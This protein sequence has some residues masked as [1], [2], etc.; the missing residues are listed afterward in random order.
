MNFLKGIRDRLSG[1]QLRAKV[2]LGIIVPLV[3]VLGLF[4]AIE[5]ARH[6]SLIMSNLSL[7][8]S[9]S[10]RVVESNL[11]EQMLKSDFVELQALLDSIGKTESFRIVYLLDPSGRVIFAPQKNGVGLQL[12]NR[13][14]DCQPCHRLS[15]SERPGSVVVTAGNGERVFRSMHPIE[16][17]PECRQCHDPQQRIIG[18]LLTDIPIAPM[19]APLNAQIRENLIWWA[20]SIL[21]VVLVVNLVINRLVLQRLKNLAMA[22]TGFGQGRLPPPLAEVQRDE[23]GQLGLAFNKM[24]GQVEARNTENYMLSESLRRQ[25]SQRGELLKRL[26]TVQEDERKRVARELHDELGQALTGLALTT[27]A[28]LRFIPSN[29]NRA[30]TEL[31]QMQHLIGDTTNQM[32]SLILDLRPSSL[33]NMGLAVALRAHAEKVLRGKGINLQLDSS[34]LSRRLPCEVEVALFRTF[35]EALNNVVRHSGATHVRITLIC[36]EGYFS[37]E[38]ADDGQ[39][40]DLATIQ[41]DGSNPR[42]L[43]LMG[44]RERV[45]I[46]GGRLEILSHPGGGVTV[47]IHI[48]LEEAYRG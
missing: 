41:L 36:Q 26:I 32:Y 35:Q 16:N 38:V 29:P 17:G 30:L 13:L 31:K 37:G 4:T 48:P 25:S 46:V 14:P 40:F 23:I 8:A 21:V 7:L 6:R 1:L 11:R 9:H 47:R 42:G 43:G 20:S 19:E 27:G 39:G 3:I 24:A 5:Q 34:G 28:A 22:I 2:T 44:M 15:P 33:D 12:D 18:L 45:G 10:G